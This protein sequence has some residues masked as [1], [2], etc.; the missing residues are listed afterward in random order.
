[1]GIKFATVAMQAS[2]RLQAM[3]MKILKHRLWKD[4]PECNFK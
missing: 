1:M 3:V 4:T 2:A